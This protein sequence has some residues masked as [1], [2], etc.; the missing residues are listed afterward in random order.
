MFDL[1]APES[2]TEYFPKLLLF[3][4]LQSHCMKLIGL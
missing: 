4:H 1:A 2:K 3:E